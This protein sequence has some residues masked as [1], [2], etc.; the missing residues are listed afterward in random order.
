MTKIGISLDDATLAALDGA[1]SN[2]SKGLSHLIE[3]RA[4][5]TRDATMRLKAAGW[6]PSELQ[7]ACAS[8]LGT[9]IDLTWSADAVAHELIAC[10]DTAA[11][12][13]DVTQQRWRELAQSV[14]DNEQLARSVVVFAQEAAAGNALVTRALEK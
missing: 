13:A 12:D 7:A 11:L 10:E 4:R 5:E 8:L 3:L 14:R 2:R 1:Y 6:N 9:Y